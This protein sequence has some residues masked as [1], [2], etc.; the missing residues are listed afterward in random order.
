[1][2]TFKEFELKLVS[3]LNSFINETLSQENIK[4]I[5]M[6]IDRLFTAVADTANHGVWVKVYESGVGEITIAF[7]ANGRRFNQSYDL[8]NHL[9]NGGCFL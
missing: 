3:I 8:Y 4:M 2:V 1:L 6:M 7:L 9:I 5:E